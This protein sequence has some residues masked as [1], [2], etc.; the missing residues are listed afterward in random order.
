YDM[1]RDGAGSNGDRTASDRLPTIVNA[2]FAKPLDEALLLELESGHRRLITLEEHSVAAGFGSAVAE[3][4]S[5]RGLNLS[6]E[7]IGV[8]NVLVQHDSQEKQRAMF[9]L[10]AAAI[11]TRVAAT[12][13]LPIAR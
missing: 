2:R 13:D 6:V 4:V 7:R 9:G 10:S 8:P 1:L 12:M 11:A 5:D 3:F